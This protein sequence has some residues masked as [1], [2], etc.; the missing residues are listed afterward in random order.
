MSVG[1]AVATCRVGDG[2]LVGVSET[3]G[4]GGIG[5]KKGVEMGTGLV[6]FTLALVFVV[7]FCLF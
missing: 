7:F 5:D 2:E 4:V 3:S 6:G 1:E